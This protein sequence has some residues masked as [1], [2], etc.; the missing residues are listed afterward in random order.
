MEVRRETHLS[1]DDVVILYFERNEQ[2]AKIHNLYLDRHGSIKTRPLVSGSSS[3]TK[4]ANCWR[5]ESVPYRGC[6]RR[7]PVPRYPQSNKGMAA[8]RER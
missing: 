1:P 7:S 3:R 5:S 6:Q 4:S 2:G 8:S